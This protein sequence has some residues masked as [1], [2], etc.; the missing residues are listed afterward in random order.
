MLLGTQPNDEQ[1]AEIAKIIDS[2]TLTPVVGHSPIEPKRAGRTSLLNPVTLTEKSPY[3]STTETEPS[4]E[5]SRDSWVQS[6]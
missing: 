4:K 6:S 3:G 1:L 2:G 5:Y